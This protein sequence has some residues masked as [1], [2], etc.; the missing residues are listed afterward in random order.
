[1]PN[2]EEK[3]EGDGEISDELGVRGGHAVAFAVHFYNRPV[4]QSFSSR[5][6]GPTPTQSFIECR[7]NARAMRVPPLDVRFG[8]SSLINLLSRK[9]SASQ[10]ICPMNMRR[11]STSRVDH[12][13]VT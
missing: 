6:S 3:G 5:L 10:P 8:L 9:L 2:Q 11:I 13:R 7:S 12:I 1:M 4:C